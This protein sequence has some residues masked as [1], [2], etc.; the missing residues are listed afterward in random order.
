MFLSKKKLS[1]NAEKIPVNQ[2]IYIFYNAN[3]DIIYIGSSNNLKDRIQEYITKYYAML[4]NHKYCKNNQL[5]VKRLDEVEKVG[6]EDFGDSSNI[7]VWKKYK[8]REK[9][10]IMNIR[11]KYCGEFSTRKEKSK[12]T[13]EVDKLNLEIEDYLKLYNK[14]KWAF[15]RIMESRFYEGE[16]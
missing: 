16:K 14:A 4:K 6:Y 15:N 9:K 13:K 1:F 7:D 2:G 12:Y 8:A 3:K 10:L 11:P 5:M